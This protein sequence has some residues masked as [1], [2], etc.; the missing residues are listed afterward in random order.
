MAPKKT[1]AAKVLEFTEGAAGKQ[2]PDHP[3]RPMNVAEVT[4]LVKMILSEM[5]ECIQTVTPNTD[6][7][8]KIVLDN[9][10]L[11]AD[12]PA[13]EAEPVKIIALQETAKANIYRQLSKWSDALG[14]DFSC[15]FN[16]VHAA[17][18]AK[19]QPDGTFRI[20][21]EDGKILKPPRWREPDINAE[22][23]RQMQHGGLESALDRPERPLIL[24]EVINITRVLLGHVIA[25]ARTVTPDA[26]SAA[27]FVGECVNTDIKRD[28][29]APTDTVKLIAEQVDA[30]VD[31]YYYILNSS[32]KM[33]V[34]LSRVIREIYGTDPVTRSR[35][36]SSYEPSAI[37]EIERQ[38]REGAWTAEDRVKEEMNPPSCEALPR[39]ESA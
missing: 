10:P 19:R 33:G 5:I 28:Y 14:V 12:F 39:N 26:A 29:R 34:N 15:V 30:W 35:N 22:I 38:I 21:P 25:L 37:V 20:R 4:F 16:V 8:I 23:Q 1:D 24:K 36:G 2:C 11:P 32:C 17:N 18:M 27:K 13:A 31:A 7:A 6:V 3:S 9:I